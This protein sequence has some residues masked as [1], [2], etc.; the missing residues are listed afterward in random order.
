V[1]GDGEAAQLGLNT[2]ELMAAPGEP[3][4]TLRSV[5]LPIGIGPMR[6]LAPHYKAPLLF[7]DKPGRREAARLRRSP[8]DLTLSE[9]RLCRQRRE[10]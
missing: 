8:L 7:L 2:D 9:K 1:S 4:L 5:H 6:A 3:Q 10:M